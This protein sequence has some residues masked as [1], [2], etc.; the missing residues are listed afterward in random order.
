MRALKGPFPQINF[1]VTGSVNL[2]NVGQFLA[3]GVTAVGVGESIFESE[4]IQAGNVDAIAVNTRRFTD[5][6]RS[7]R[8]KAN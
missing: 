3:A 7:A 5:A 6:I 4:A 8:S 2:E 1:V